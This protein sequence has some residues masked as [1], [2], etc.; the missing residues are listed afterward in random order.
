MSEDTSSPKIDNRAQVYVASLV[1]AVTLAVATGGSGAVAVAPEVF[2]PI[3]WQVR[4]IGGGGRPG[5]RERERK[6]RARHL[7]DARASGVVSRGALPRHPGGLR[8]RT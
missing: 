7:R 2:L 1:A 6:R 3:A 8:C 4:G 5:V